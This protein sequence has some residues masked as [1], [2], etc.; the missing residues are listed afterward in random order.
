MLPLIVQLSSQLQLGGH[1]WGA[2]G[3]RDHQLLQQAPA[4]QLR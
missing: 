3:R 4:V 2:G 1:M